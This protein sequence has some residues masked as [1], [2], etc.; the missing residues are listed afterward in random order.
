MKELISG[1]EM[2]LTLGNKK[3]PKTTA[4][5]C[6]T[7][8]YKGTCPSAKLGLCKHVDI[9]Y[10]RK[11]EERYHHRLI[12]FRKRQTKYWDKVNARQFVRDLLEA[13][14][15]RKS[16]NKLTALRMS[17]S[18]DFRNQKDFNK[19]NSIANQLKKHGIRVYTY[20]ARKDL[21]FSKLS[22]NFTLNGS[23]FMIDN[24]FY[25]VGKDEKV[26]GPVCPADCKICTM[27]QQKKGRNIAVRKH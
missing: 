6:I 4:I 10:A 19:V 2:P 12:P 9:C 25:V 1:N 14:S 11:M 17:E 22:E 15:K 21:N 13:N 8:A 16:V 3:L 26:N 27:C 7:G 23:E 5:F 18:G 20:T 24:N